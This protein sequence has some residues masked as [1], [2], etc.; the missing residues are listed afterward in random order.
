MSQGFK[1]IPIL[2]TVW[3]T[4]ALAT[5]F[6]QVLKMVD[7]TP[8][9]DCAHFSIESNKCDK[10]VP[11]TLGR[12]IAVVLSQP[13]HMPVADDVLARR[14]ASKVV[15]AKEIE[16]TPDEIIRI[17]TRMSEMT[18]NPII[19]GEAIEAIDPAGTK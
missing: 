14:L 4:P 12:F 1:Y 8:V 5:D 7:G 6:S 16:L 15:D 9:D 17:K 13:S 11:L 2:A 10:I 3:L 19:K 18:Y